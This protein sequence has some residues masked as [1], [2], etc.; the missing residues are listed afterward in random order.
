MVAH[1]TRHVCGPVIAAICDGAALVASLGTRLS[2]ST[3][4]HTIAAH[5][6]LSAALAAHQCSAT[7]VAHIA[8][9]P[10]GARSKSLAAH[11][12]HAHFPSICAA[13][14][15]VQSLVAAVVDSSAHS[16][17]AHCLRYTHALLC[18]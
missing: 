3:H 2:A 8:A 6:A 18:D 11:V 7:P 13:R 1:P 10:H 16:N 12:I 15:T 9:V 5:L 4:A 14:P 17:V